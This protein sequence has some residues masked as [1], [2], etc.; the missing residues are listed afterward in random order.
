MPF[1]HFNFIAGFYDW[2]GKFTVTEPLFGFLALSP[3]SLVLDAGGGTG[4]VAAEIRGMVREVFVA[5]ISRGMLRRAAGKGLPAVCSPAESLPF[6]AGSF[7]RVIMVDALHHVL[8]QERTAHELW[9]VLA[10]GGKIVIVEPDIH[11]FVTRLIAIGEKLLRMR[12]HFLSG[13]EIASLFANADAKT[14][15]HSDEFNV[16]FIAEKARKM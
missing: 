10:S 2:A 9:R 13:A 3:N 6:L 7:D 8:N 15:I 5:D 16:I 14:S 12:S 11:K 4:R 1:D